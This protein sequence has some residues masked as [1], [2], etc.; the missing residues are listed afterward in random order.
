ML[1]YLHQYLK[2]RLP[3][4]KGFWFKL[5]YSSGR[6]E[7][8]KNFQCDTFP[9]FQI[10]KN[11]K[12]TI[13]DNVQFRRN[14]EIRSHGN[15]K[16]TIESNVRIDR[17]VRLLATNNSH[18]YIKTGARIGLYT[19]FNGGDSITIGEK[20]LI[21]GFIYLQTSMH[22][23]KKGTNVQEQGY[24]H[25]PIFLEKDVWIGTHAVILPGCIIGEGSVIGSNAVVTK[26]IEKEMVVGGVP[27]KIL[28]ERM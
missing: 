23:Y 25:A 5:L 9:F 24:S 22:N 26:S 28:K 7:I 16:I 11:C 18:I 20:V 3:F 17:G 27:A 2:K 6:L 15:S 21:S 19:V 12:L 13:G 8:G 4:W 14:I 10:D 1:F